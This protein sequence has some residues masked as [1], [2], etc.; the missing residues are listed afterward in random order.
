[1]DEQSPKACEVVLNQAEE[2][3]THKCFTYHW[4]WVL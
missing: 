4:N 2:F 1:L 3:N